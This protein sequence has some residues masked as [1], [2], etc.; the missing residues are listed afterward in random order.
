LPPLIR[1]SGQRPSQEAKAEA[2][3]NLWPEIASERSSFLCAI[4]QLLLTG[5]SHSGRKSHFQT[6]GDFSSIAGGPRIPF[7]SGRRILKQAKAES[8]KLQ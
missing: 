7:C 8:A 4:D 6:A 3:R 2:W 5:R 1:F